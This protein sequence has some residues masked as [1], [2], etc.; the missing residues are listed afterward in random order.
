M[1]ISQLVL[2][3]TDGRRLSCAQVFHNI[4][5]QSTRPPGNY[6]PHVARSGVR[7]GM[8]RLRFVLAADVIH[9]HELN[10]AARAQA[11]RKGDRPG[12]TAGFGWYVGGHAFGF[13]DN[14]EEN[15]D[16]TI[17]IS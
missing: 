12:A 3:C 1:W 8:A 2:S 11:N 13:S 10:V 4:Y 14:R 17:E 5:D 15:S 7:L 6:G 16:N 9:E